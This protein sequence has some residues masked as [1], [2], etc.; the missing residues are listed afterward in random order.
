[1][2]VWWKSLVE[3]MWWIQLSLGLKEEAEGDFPI[4]VYRLDSKILAIYY[5]ALVH[6][7]SSW[8]VWTEIKSLALEPVCC[9]TRQKSSS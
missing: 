2:C 5:L 9:K 6:S 8:L 4:T 3:K 7:I 1:M